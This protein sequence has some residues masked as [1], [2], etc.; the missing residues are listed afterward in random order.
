MNDASLPEIR[1][2]QRARNFYCFVPGR[3]PIISQS[4][5]QSASPDVVLG[6]LSTELTTSSLLADVE[7]INQLYA[8]LNR[9]VKFEQ[10]LRPHENVV[11]RRELRATSVH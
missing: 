7:V 8:E 9:N 3:M 10:S 1:K 5:S 2:V 6:T 4:F 11:T